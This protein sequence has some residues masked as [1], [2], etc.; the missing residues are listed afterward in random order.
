[1]RTLSGYLPV[2]A[3]LAAVT[4]LSFLSGGYIFE[5]TATV[6]FVALGAAVV[7]VWLLPRRAPL[8]L[9]LAVGLAALALF[10][11]W[12][13]LSIVWSIGPDLS[14]LAFDVALLYLV[15]AVVATITP[16]GPGQLRLAGYGYVVAIVPVAAYALLGK[17]LPDVV[18]H[19]HLYARLMAPVGYWNVLAMM[20]VMASLPALEGAARRGLPAAARG[21]LAAALALFLFTAFFT[22]S[23][24]GTVALIVALA[25]YFVLTNERLQSALSLVLAAGPVALALYHARPLQTLFDAT[26]NDALRTAQGHAF[27]HTVLLAI[28]AVALLQVMAALVTR[29]VPLRGLARRVV[30]AVVLAAALAAVVVGG[31]AFAG[32]YGGVDGVFHKAADQFRNVET[33]GTTSNGAGRLLSLGN[34]GR[35]PMVRNALK[36]YRDHPVTGSGAGTYRFTNY[37]YRSGAYFIVKHAHDQWANIMSELGLVGL[38]LYVTGIGGLLV[39]ALRPGGRGARDADRGLLAALQA[40]AVAFLV[41]LTVDWDWDMAPATF[42]FLLFAGV[43]AAYVRDRR[44]AVAAA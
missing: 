25:L 8:G 33:G 38:V 9:P 29:R 40:A 14:W 35:I 16:A 43:A 42:S 17:V 21:A 32:R 30:G 4:A 1:M 12:T 34:N 28:V 2:A 37:L 24:G 26:A 20:M 27:G 10:V 39:A 31:L 7:W 23:R 22:F 19:A 41:H 3:L 36:G 11:G 15:V 18:T 6:A 13:G 5:R 44:A